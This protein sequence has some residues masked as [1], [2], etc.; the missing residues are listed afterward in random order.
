MT[1]LSRGFRGAW[2]DDQP[3]EHRHT[4]HRENQTITHTDLPAVEP[5]LEYT[6][7]PGAGLTDR[8]C[9]LKATAV[10]SWREGLAL[11]MRQGQRGLQR[12]VIAMAEAMAFSRGL[13]VGVQ[14]CQ[15][16]GLI[17][18]S[19]VMT[20]E[21]YVMDDENPFVYGE[22][23]TAAAFA[24]REAERE[25]LAQDLPGRPEDLSDLSP[26]LWQVVAGARRHARAG[27]A[28]DPHRRSHRLGLELV[29]RLSRIVR[30][31]TGRGRDAH[32]PVAAMG[33]RPA[34]GGPPRAA[35]RHRRR[36]ARPVSHSRS[37]RSGPRA[38]R[39]GSR[40]KSSRCRRASPPRAGSGWPSC[41]TSS[42]R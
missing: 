30:P 33:R 37:P 4:E 28:E 13:Q 3:G 15:R 2:A 22:I 14:T 26:P 34:E 27:A 39:H 40:P 7:R 38:K 16:R 10:G 31:G 18:L 36:R 42:R 19:Y 5:T 12:E 25:R 9:H 29:C 35:L 41:S 1:G 17:T 24:D 32:E 21:N 8:G 11:A 23:V 20:T 6:T